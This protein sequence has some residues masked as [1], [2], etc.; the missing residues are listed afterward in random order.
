M[1][2]FNEPMRR[3]LPKINVSQEELDRAY[4]HIERTLSLP[5]SEQNATAIEEAIKLI[6]DGME[7]TCAIRLIS[8][9]HGID[10]RHLRS[11]VKLTLKHGNLKS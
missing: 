6:D 8:A 9:R 4:A 1:G 5:T 3:K 11:Q 10:F 7:K 2:I